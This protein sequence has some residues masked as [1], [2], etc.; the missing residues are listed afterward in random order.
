[1]A[2]IDSE[3]ESS[4]GSS[5][6]RGSKATGQVGNSGARKWTVAQRK[7]FLRTMREKR[8]ARTA[9]KHAAKTVSTSVARYHKKS[10]P[11]PTGVLQF[12]PAALVRQVSDELYE[13]YDRTGKRFNPTQL[14]I[15]LAAAEDE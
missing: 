10:K 9:T 8:K 3:K 6:K 4:S 7:K 15:L 12:A 5:I 14:K 1:M 2:Q 11:K 13:A